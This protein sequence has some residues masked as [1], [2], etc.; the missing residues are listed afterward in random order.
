MPSNIIHAAKYR[1]FITVQNS[2]IVGV[3]IAQ[4]LS[5]GYLLEERNTQE[6]NTILIQSTTPVPILLGI[7]ALWIDGA[8]RRQGI[9]TR[10]VDAIRNS[11]IYNLVISKTQVAFSQPTRMGLSFATD[12]LHPHPVVVYGEENKQEEITKKA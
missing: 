12:Y 2:N 10:L 6:E 5:I 7:H 3:V 9:S 8:Y 1:Y 11:F 4:Q